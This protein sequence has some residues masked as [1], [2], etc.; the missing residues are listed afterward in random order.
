MFMGPNPFDAKVDILNEVAGNGF[1]MS[2]FS[3]ELEKNFNSV[4]Q[5]M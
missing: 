4:S 2:D 1:Y 5:E 3:D